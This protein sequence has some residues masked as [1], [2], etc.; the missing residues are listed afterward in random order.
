MKKII[1]GFILFVTL[2]SYAQTEIDSTSVAFKEDVVKAKPIDGIENFK[3]KF[4]ESFSIPTERILEINRK[5]LSLIISFQV[6]ENGKLNHIKV[7]NDKY[8]LT[9]EI[10][11]IFTTLPDWIPAKKNG[12]NVK[13]FNSFPITINFR[14]PDYEKSENSLEK[15]TALETEYKAFY[16]EFNSHM[17]YPRD[18]W[19]RY[20]YKKGA[21]ETGENKTSNEFKYII[22]FTINEEG[23]FENI[24]TFINEKPDEYLNKAVKRS[25]AKCTP[26]EPAIE[27]G[28]KVKSNMRLPVTIT[29]KK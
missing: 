22:E 20:Y 9:S 10:N 8:K 29:I 6:D 2:V 7:L 14:L 25:L 23:N 26:W 13:S 28:K 5:Q 12:I 17:I 16:Y 3:L 15:R 27:N 21:Y 19:E 18:F 4:A 1:L 11:Q 24:K